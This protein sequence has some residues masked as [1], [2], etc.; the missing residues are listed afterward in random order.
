M[1]SSNVGKIGLPAA[2]PAFASAGITHT[3][4][5]MAFAV[6]V[7]GFYAVGVGLPMGKFSAGDLFI[8]LAAYRM[9]VDYN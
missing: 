3:T 6:P 2:L 8:V 1:M 7:A 5:T 9:V 4:R